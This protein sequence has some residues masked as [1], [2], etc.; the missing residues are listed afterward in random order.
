MVVVIVQSF[1]DYIDVLSPPL[2]LNTL[3]PNI[4]SNQYLR[5]EEEHW[6]CM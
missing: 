6:E 3:S 5:K 2:P 4:C 1:R